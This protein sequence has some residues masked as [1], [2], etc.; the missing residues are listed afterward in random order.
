MQTKPWAGTD[1]VKE[2][3][4]Y[5]A[6]HVSWDD[7]IKYCRKLSENDGKSYRLP[8]EAEWEYACR[9][10]T[11]TAYSFGN[12]A[13]LLNDHAWFAANTGGMGEAYTHE[14]GAKRANPF[15]LYDMHGNVGEWCYDWYGWYD[16]SSTVDPTGPLSGSFRVFRGGNYSVGAGR[17]RSAYRNS[18]A[19]TYRS[20]SSDLGF[21]LALSPSV[22]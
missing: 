7:A 14:V 2:G 22:R 20:L 16:S 19:P 10:G 1:A 15:G 13:D 8:T 21:R 4:S 6:S 18:L 5:P 3:D 17:C 11:N 12:N 9:G